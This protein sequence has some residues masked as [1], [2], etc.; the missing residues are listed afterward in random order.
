MDPWAASDTNKVTGTQ[1]NFGGSVRTTTA[2]TDEQYQMVTLTATGDNKSRL[3][4]L[5]SNTPTVGEVVLTRSLTNVMDLG[6]VELKITVKGTYSLD[7]D[8]WVMVTYPTYYNPGLGNWNMPRCVWRDAENANDAETVFC[9]AMWDWCMFVKGPKTAVATAGAAYL[10]I[11]GVNMNAFTT[12]GTWG[13]GLFNQTSLTNH[14]VNE[15]GEVTDGT[16]GA[17]G[18]VLPI[19]I[20][21]LVVSNTAMRSSTTVTID[22]TLPTTQGTVTDGADYVALELPW[23]V[24]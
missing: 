7:G 23:G 22:F 17:W 3:G 12:A 14:Q 20:D 15:W 24:F 21:A 13:V 9:A 1:S 2:T 16:T 10:R 5:T 18:G 4:S 11:F 8:S 19:T 6:M